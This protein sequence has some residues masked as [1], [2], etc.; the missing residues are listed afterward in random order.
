LQLEL[1][2]QVVDRGAFVA[3]RDEDPGRGIEDSTLRASSRKTVTAAGQVVDAES[4]ATS[5]R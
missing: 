5:M 1:R 3:A 4:W 2:Y